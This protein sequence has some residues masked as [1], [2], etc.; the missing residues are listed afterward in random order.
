MTKT[1]MR[2]AG[3]WIEDGYV[4]LESFADV[5][6]WGI[7]GGSLEP[8]ESVEKGCLREYREELGL[9]MQADGIALINENFWPDGDEIIREY[10]FYFLV[11]PKVES[12][13]ACIDVRSKESQLQFRWFRLDELHT[14]DF[15]PPF[16]RAVLPRL[17]KQTLFMST[18]EDGIKATG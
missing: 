6:V 2:T 17:G 10:C 3:I 8:D 12:L 15:V 4:L 14:I 11:R 9:E 16:L 13:R 1:A 5:E 7:P 18:A